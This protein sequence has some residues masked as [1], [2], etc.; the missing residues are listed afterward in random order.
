MRVSK[1]NT[2]QA[3]E[4]GV[5]SHDDVRA[6]S[7]I[8]DRFLSRVDRRRNKAIQVRGRAGPNLAV[9]VHGCKSK[10]D[11]AMINKMLVA[12]LLGAVLLIASSAR[13]QEDGFMRHWPDRVFVPR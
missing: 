1:S 8:G 11:M 4:A 5:L 2:N 9:V 3:G 7:C 10:G 12:G 13:A 6:L